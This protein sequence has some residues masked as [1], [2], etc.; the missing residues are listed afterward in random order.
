VPPSPPRYQL[1]NSASSYSKDTSYDMPHQW[2]P[3]P[4][5][6]VSG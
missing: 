2:Q 5:L 4:Q 6:G 3:I 1:E